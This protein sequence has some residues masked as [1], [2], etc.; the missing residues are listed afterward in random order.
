MSEEQQDD[1]ASSV[2][3][4]LS[5]IDEKLEHIVDIF[6][7]KR[8]TT[9]SSGETQTTLYGTNIGSVLK[10]IDGHIADLVGSNPPAKSADEKVEWEYWVRVVSIKP[11]DG[12]QKEL[13][14]LGALGWELVNVSLGD[15][16][17]L[18]K[19]TGL[20]KD[21]QSQAASLIAFFKRRKQY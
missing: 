15:W 10:R 21:V 4:L 2:A 5:E 20:D 18:T 16:Y 13:N 3:D 9:D 17:T 11:F 19:P 14:S 6:Y 1:R 12:I 8:T 7:D